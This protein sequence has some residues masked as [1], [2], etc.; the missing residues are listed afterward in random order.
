MTAGKKR[1]HGETTQHHSSCSGNRNSDQRFLFDG[2][3]ETGAQGLI[4]FMQLG[5]ELLLQ[6]INGLHHMLTHGAKTSAGGHFRLGDG[7]LTVTGDLMLIGRNHGNCTMRVLSCT[8][9]G[10]PGGDA[11]R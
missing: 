3:L 4:Q 7:G 5:V 11:V 1:Q 8:S 10:D 9:H 2:L 6:R